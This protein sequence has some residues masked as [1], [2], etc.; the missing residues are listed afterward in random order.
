MTAA[1]QQRGV[2]L[3]S[4]SRPLRPDDLSTFDYIVGMDQKNLQAMLVCIC[5]QPKRQFEPKWYL[6]QLKQ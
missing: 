2:I 4:Q 1:A 5:F 3:T 6:L